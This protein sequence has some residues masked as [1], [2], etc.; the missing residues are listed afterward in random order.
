MTRAPQ[1]ADHT[2]H[3]HVDQPSNGLGVAG[4]VLSILGWI[5]CG[6]LLPFGL[7]FSFIGLF[8]RPRG[9]AIAGFVIS[10]V[11]A[12]LAVS[13]V[14]IIGI[15]GAAALIGISQATD[16]VLFDAAAEDIAYHYSTHGSLPTPSEASASLSLYANLRGYSPQYAIVSATEFELRFPGSDGIFGNADDFTQVFDVT[17]LA[18]SAGPGGASISLPAS[19]APGTNP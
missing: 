6:L 17:T 4:F 5:T 16:A 12:L 15:G 11:G 9:L 14:A 2:T 3:V 18:P 19:P 1:T 8:K 13:V 10:S 7:L